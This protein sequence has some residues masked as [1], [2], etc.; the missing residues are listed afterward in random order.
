MIPNVF[1]F[2]F[3]LSD[4]FGGKPFNLPHYLA[5]KSSIQV[6]NPDKVYFYYKHLPQS[7]WFE[8]IKDQIELVKVDPPNQIFNNPLYHVAHQADIIRNVKRKRW[9]LHGY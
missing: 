6:N 2:I 9:N 4:D 7:K 8:K 3:G 1:H 5:I